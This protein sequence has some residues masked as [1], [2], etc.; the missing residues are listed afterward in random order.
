MV[1]LAPSSA[2]MRKRK[3]DPWGS[4][5][6]QPNLICKPQVRVRDCLSNHEVASG[7]G[8]LRLSSDLHTLTCANVSSHVYYLTHEH[9]H[10]PSLSGQSTEE[11]PKWSLQLANLACIHTQP[12]N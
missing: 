7:S 12:G 4:P 10:I 8:L 6:S 9:T 11:T 3:V 5:A 1:E 2:L